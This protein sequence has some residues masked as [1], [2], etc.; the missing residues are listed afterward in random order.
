MTTWGHFSSKKTFVEVVSTFVLL[1]QK[2]TLLG[3]FE[4]K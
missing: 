2:E 1:P 3:F 4:K